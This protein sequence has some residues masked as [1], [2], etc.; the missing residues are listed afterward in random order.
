[1]HPSSLMYGYWAQQVAELIVKLL[2]SSTTKL[3]S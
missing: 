2:D 3:S 1:F